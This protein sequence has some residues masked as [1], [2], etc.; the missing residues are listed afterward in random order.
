MTDTLEIKA[1]PRPVSRLNKKMVILVSGLALSFLIGVGFYALE[2]KDKQ[3]E[4]P[5]ELYN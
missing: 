3:N 4:P 5:K 1:K 2:S